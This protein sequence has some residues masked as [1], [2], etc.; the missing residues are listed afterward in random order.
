MAKASGRGAKTDRTSR[1][2]KK[3][4]ASA[5]KVFLSHLAAT[6]NVT[7]S[8]KKAGISK[9]LVYTEH[10]R[11][12]IFQRQWLAALSK[13]YALLEAQLLEEALKDARGNIKDATLKARAQKHRLALALLAAHRGRVTGQAAAPRNAPK[14]N[15]AQQKAELI[16]RLNLMRARIEQNKTILDG[17]GG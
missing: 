13:G 10:G 9:S 11:S 3:F 17:N 6:A 5:R 4:D 14:K 8:A 16:A 7:A 1:K 15:T 2:A 12:E